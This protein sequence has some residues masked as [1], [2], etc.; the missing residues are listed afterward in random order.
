MLGRFKVLFVIH[1]WNSFSLCFDILFHFIHN[2]V[3]D[4]QW[5]IHYSWLLS[6]YSGLQIE[7]LYRHDF[8]IMTKKTQ[9]E[10]QCI[11]I[12]LT[13]PHFPGNSCSLYALFVVPRS[14]FLSSISAFSSASCAASSCSS[15]WTFSVEEIWYTSS[16]LPISVWQIKR[17]SSWEEAPFARVSNFWTLDLENWQCKKHKFPLLYTQY[18]GYSDF[19]KELFIQHLF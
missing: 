1:T 16:I 2:S 12:N 10:T 15:C 17:K 18:L 6:I 7:Q 13:L 9:K 14:I 11:A 8:C 19:I 5:K 4:M 3:V